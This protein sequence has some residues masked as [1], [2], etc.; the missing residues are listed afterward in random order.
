MIPEASHSLTKKNQ[1]ISNEIMSW[2]GLL[3]SQL[4]MCEGEKTKKNTILVLLFAT[5]KKSMTRFSWDHSGVKK[6]QFS[7]GRDPQKRSNHPKNG[8]TTFAQTPY[9]PKKKSQST[10]SSNQKNVRKGQTI[11]KKMR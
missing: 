9:V 7:C 1:K 4:L 2:L 3:A 8:Q 10:L 6:Y 5:P 11:Q